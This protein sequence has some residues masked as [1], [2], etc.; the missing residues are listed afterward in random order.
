[1]ACFAPVADDGRVACVPTLVV[2]EVRQLKSNRSKDMGG[3]WWNRKE[4]NPRVWVIT[5]TT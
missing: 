2:Q 1:M 4:R 5:L 3:S